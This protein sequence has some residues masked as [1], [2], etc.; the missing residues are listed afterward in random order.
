MTADNLF[1]RCLLPQL[2]SEN[3]TLSIAN[4]IFLGVKF[5]PKESFLSQVRDDFFS[6]VT[7]VNFGKSKKA[8]G[9]INKWVAGE[10]RNKIRRLVSAGSLSSDT[11][12][13]LVNAIYFKANW[14]KKFDNKLTKDKQFHTKEVREKLVVPMMTMR[15]RFQV[16]PQKGERGKNNRNQKMHQFLVQVTQI[17]KLDTMAIRLPYTGAG[18][19]K[20]REPGN[21]VPR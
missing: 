9:T 16:L 3:F 1:Q 7:E 21:R 12:M 17:E 2:V 5:S 18:W 8:A 20:V 19:H 4:K 6:N 10:T 13:V 14:A 15:S 11:R